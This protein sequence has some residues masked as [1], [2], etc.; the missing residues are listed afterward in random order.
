MNPQSTA[1]DQETVIH[2]MHDAFHCRNFQAGAQLFAP[3]FNNHG[4]QLPREAIIAVW[5]DICT[6]FPDARLGIV[7]LSAEEHPLGRGGRL[8]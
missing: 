3:I 6:R 4:V 2:A 5:T 8:S 1:T 7:T